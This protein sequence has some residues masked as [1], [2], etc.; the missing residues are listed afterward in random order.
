MG[1]LDMK[2]LRNNIRSVFGLLNKLQPVWWFVLRLWI[3]KVFFFSG[4]TKIEDF[5]VT[6]FLFE[7]EYAVPFFSAYFAAVSAT[8]FELLMP[9]FIVLGFATRFAVL[10]L[11]VMTAVIQFTYKE[12]VE[13]L[14]WVILL[15]GLLVHGAGKLS[16]DYLLSRKYKK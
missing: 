5:D 6:L 11:I 8:F 9:V 2:F 3:A 1:K 15:S 13:H 4:L 10:P 12:H 14:Y 7:N 16:V